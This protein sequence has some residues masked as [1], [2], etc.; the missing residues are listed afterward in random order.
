MARELIKRLAIEKSRAAVA[1]TSG[2]A[3]VTANGGAIM[4]STDRKASSAPNTLLKP[5]GPLQPEEARENV[6]P[7]S[8]GEAAPA[9]EGRRPWRAGGVTLFTPPD[10]R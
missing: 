4:G 6:K 5:G 10:Q 1:G 2:Q 8:W 9:H 3:E 7:V